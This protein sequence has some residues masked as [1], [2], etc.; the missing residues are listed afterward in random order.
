MLK[1][2]LAKYDI[3]QTII[4][5]NSALRPSYS[6][7]SQ[8]ACGKKIS[9]DPIMIGGLVKKCDPCKISKGF[10]LSVFSTDKSSFLLYVLGTFTPTLLKNVSGVWQTTVGSFG[11]IYPKGFIPNEPFYAGVVIDWNTVFATHGNG[12]YKLNIAIGVNNFESYE[13][14]CSQYSCLAADKTIYLQCSM[15][16]GYLGDPNNQLNQINFTD[17]DWIEYHRIPAAIVSEEHQHESTTYN[18]G[19]KEVVTEIMPHRATT[20]TKFTVKTSPMPV[21]YLNFLMQIMK[22][23]VVLTSDNEKDFSDKYKKFLC[24]SDQASVSFTENE[25]LLGASLRQMTVNFMPKFVNK[26]NLNT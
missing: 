4:Y 15:P 18:I 26:M 16:K 10:R 7:V 12:I 6:M 23:K 22:F 17:Y 24:I 20:Q 1:T 14:V 9:T 2:Q 19:R 5:P 11:T 8:I 25:I 3:M 13:Y 21:D